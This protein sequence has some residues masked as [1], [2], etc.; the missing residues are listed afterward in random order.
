MTPSLSHSQTVTAPRPRRHTG[1][2]TSWMAACLVAACAMIAPLPAFAQAEER[3]VEE[4]ARQ[5]EDVQAQLEREREVLAEIEAEIDRIRGD[6]SELNA[7]LIET[8][9]TVKQHEA[10]ILEAEDRLA[11]FAGREETLRS[12]FNAQRGTLASLLGALQLMSHR[13]PPAIVVAP[14]DALRSV[15]SAMLVGAVVP[16]IRSDTENLAADLEELVALRTAAEEE[17]SRRADALASLDDDRVRLKALMDA[18]AENALAAR[19]RLEAARTR[20]DR[21]ATESENL[22]QLLTALRS[23]PA[24]DPTRPAEAD[25]PAADD[26][27]EDERLQPAS[28]FVSVRGTLNYPVAG[29]I[30]RN[31]GSPDEFGGRTRGLSLTSRAEA[32]VTAP[33]DGTIVY[34]G[35]FRSYGE[36]LIIDVGDDYH[37]VLAGLGEINVDVGQVVLAGEPI[38]RMGSVAFASAADQ[39]E[40]GGRPIL[41]IEFRK[42]GAAIDPSPWWSANQTGVEG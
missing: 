21:L 41:Y 32:Q 5:L 27:P 38:G 22:E 12:N 29:A 7:R 13:Q 31:Y 40:S 37:I 4:T 25:R 3:D 16:S 20:A 18:K 19:E 10:A 36:L 30:L 35:P 9:A 24:P 1:P 34:S 6:Q 17:R 33:T 11:G 2:G 28:R 23:R 42:G 8:A 39:P 15:R 14:E 26:I